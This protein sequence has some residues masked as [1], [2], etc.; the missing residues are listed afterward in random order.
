[1][2]DQLPDNYFDL[3]H[4]PE[5]EPDRRS[6]KVRES[7][8]GLECRLRTA[9]AEIVYLKKVLAD[10][11]ALEKENRALRERQEWCE[12]RIAQL[13]RQCGAQSAR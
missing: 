7:S 10:Y 11:R 1:M 12:D 2:L 9:L 5:T 4:R 8:V 13:E 3:L 6:G